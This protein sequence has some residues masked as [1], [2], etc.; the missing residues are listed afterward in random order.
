MPPQ[1]DPGYQGQHGFALHWTSSKYQYGGSLLGYGNDVY[2]DIMIILFIMMMI[3]GM[4]MI[5][6]MMMMMMMRNVL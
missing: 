3:V 1:P 2:D 4:M 5:M 6:M